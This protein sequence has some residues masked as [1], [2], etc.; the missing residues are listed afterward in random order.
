M[1]KTYIKP[2]TEIVQIEVEQVIAVSG[3]DLSFG[4]DDN[5]G[6]VSLNDDYADEVLSR[7][8]GV[9]GFDD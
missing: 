5:S 2:S 3:G 6:S 9:L 8:R 4:S 1:K 7:G